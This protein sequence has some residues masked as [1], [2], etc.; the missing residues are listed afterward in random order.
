V[1]AGQV[2]HA[3]A[4]SQ[5]Q[6]LPGQLRDSLIGRFSAREGGSMH[7]ELTDAGRRGKKVQVVLVVHRYG[8][9]QVGHA[10]EQ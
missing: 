9:E 7:R 8:V 2:Q 10:G 6:Q 5:I 1:P 4:W 3:H